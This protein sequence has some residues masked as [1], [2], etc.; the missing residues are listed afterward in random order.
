MVRTSFA[1]AV[2]IVCGIAAMVGRHGSGLSRIG[3]ILL[4]DSAVRTVPNSISG[5]CQTADL[6]VA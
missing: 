4:G 6:P 5:G 1:L 2:I 3:S